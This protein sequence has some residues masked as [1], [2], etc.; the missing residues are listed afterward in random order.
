MPS[1]IDKTPVRVCALCSLASCSLKCSVG[2]EAV[3]RDDLSAGGRCRS[4]RV[5][6][7][8][9]PPTRQSRGP[10]SPV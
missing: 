2:L 7:M 8:A 4:R 3:A 1:T 10:C 9:R 6:V 5:G